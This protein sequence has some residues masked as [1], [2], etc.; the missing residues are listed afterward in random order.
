MQ[1]IVNK[2]SYIYSEFFVTYSDYRLPY[3]TVLFIDFVLKESR[4]TALVLLKCQKY[5]FMFLTF[6]YSLKN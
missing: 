5:V 3:T 2:T 1:D 6:F 4:K